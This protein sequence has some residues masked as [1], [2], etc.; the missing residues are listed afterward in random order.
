ML[1]QP[2]CPPFYRHVSKSFL[3]NKLHPSRVIFKGIGQ[4]SGDVVIMP[5]L[6]GKK[7]KKQTS[8]ILNY[9]HR[10]HFGLDFVL[11]FQKYIHVQKPQ[12]KM[13]PCCK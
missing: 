13:S 8:S 5:F 1:P 3:Q 11:V 10:A 9:I 12:E 6:P 4:D 2:W 7:K